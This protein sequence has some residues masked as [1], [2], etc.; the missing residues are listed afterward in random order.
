MTCRYCTSGAMQLAP[1]EEPWRLHAAHVASLL[2]EELSASEAGRVSFEQ[3]P[4][5][6]FLGDMPGPS[7]DAR[8]V[9]ACNQLVDQ[10]EGQTVLAF[11]AIDTADEAT[12]ETLA[13][14][15]QR[16]GWLRLPLLLTMRGT[17]RGRV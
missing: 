9:A 3:R 11:E 10:T 4:R 5:Q 16:V 13:H 1:A 17:P 14:I 2:G 6:R 12:M 8:L 7:L 15:L